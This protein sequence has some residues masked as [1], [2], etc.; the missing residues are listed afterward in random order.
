MPLHVPK[1]GW[2]CNLLRTA[3][4]HPAKYSVFPIFS[5]RA[6]LTL[7]ANNYS[8]DAAALVVPVKPWYGE[9]AASMVGLWDGTRAL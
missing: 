3:R 6:D 5:S 8:F 1:F 4:Q 7:W 9:R 2:G